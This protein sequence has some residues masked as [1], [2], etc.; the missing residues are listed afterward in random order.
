MKI[1]YFNLLLT[2]LR[3]IM[4]STIFLVLFLIVIEVTL[5]GC[6]DNRPE[7]PYS[8]IKPLIIHTDLPEEDDGRGG[9]IAVD[10]TGDNYMD[11]IVTK[12]GHIA[13]ISNSGETLWHRQVDIQLTRKSEK[14]GLPGLHA[15]GVQ[16]ADV[17]G[18][19]NVEVLFLTQDGQLCVI[20]G[21]TGKTRI[22]VPLEPPNGAERW[23]H[24]VVSNMLGQGDSALI[25]QAT[26]ARGYRMGSHVAALYLGSLIEV[27][28]ATYLWKRDDFLANAHSGTRVADVDLDGKDEITGGMILDHKGHVL[29]TL[30]LL[31]HIDSIFVADVRPDLVGLEVLALEE[32][33]GLWLFSGRNPMSRLL[34]KLI[35]GIYIRLFSKGNNV[36]L[37]NHD[38]L[39]WRVDYRQREPQNAGVG[40]FDPSLPGLEIWCRSRFNTHQKPFV[41]DAYGDLIA[42]YELDDLA[43]KG[44]T[45]K[46]VEEIST[47]D[48]SGDAKQLLAAKERHVSGNVAVFDAI[49]GTFLE[50][51][52][53]KADR[54]YVAD[55]YGD[56]REELIIMN[57]NELHIYVNDQRNPNPSTSTLWQ[58]NYYRR[59]KMTWNYYNP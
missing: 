43:P 17:D 29:I 4:S 12:P 14:F 34:N 37:Y 21:K 35:N 33:N 1:A 27:D 59:S 56:F 6:Q 31:G 52:N 41:L 54:L 32:E 2:L 9:V 11:F 42:T 15:P 16:A 5:V 28:I 26:N 38:S 51:F 23:E 8:T 44:W 40:D 58:N 18:D 47:I 53:E 7:L 45:V 19:E 36:Y 39:I 22:N 30:P 10:L 20:D 50:L 3:C 25:L 48:W 24:L 55:V 49:S 13:A 46:G 57:G